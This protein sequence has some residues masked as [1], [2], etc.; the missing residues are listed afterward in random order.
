MKLFEVANKVV[1][2]EDDNH[3][4]QALYAHVSEQGIGKN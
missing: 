4:V 3:M 2:V 1:A